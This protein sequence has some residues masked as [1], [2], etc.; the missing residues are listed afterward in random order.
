MSIVK[1]SSFELGALVNAKVIDAYAEAM[2][3][4]M[5]MEDIKAVVDKFNEQDQLISKAKEFSQLRAK[6]AAL[7]AATYRKIV[8]KGWQDA[9]GSK[10]SNRRQAAEWLANS[11]DYEEHIEEILNG[12]GET[13]VSIWKNVCKQNTVRSRY[14]DYIGRKHTLLDTYDT[15]GAVTITKLYDPDDDGEVPQE[16][17]LTALQD[18]PDSHEEQQ[19]ANTQIAFGCRHD[20]WSLGKEWE[21]INKIDEIEDAVTDST[22]IALRKRGAVGVG[23]GRYIDPE[24]HPEELKKALV[25]RKRNICY[26]IK[27]LFEIC[28]AI[29]GADF[30]TECNEAVNM[31]N[32][33]LAIVELGTGGDAE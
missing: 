15:L 16:Q 5:H 12:D 10:R 17:Y 14:K 29:D 30:I 24:K 32:L 1:S 21:L 33:P 25:I 6:Y 8:I 2:T 19:D 23:C 7:E 13:I 18:Y 9:L 27:K 4:V 20:H 3:N 31:T 28:K 22:R 11:P 26:C